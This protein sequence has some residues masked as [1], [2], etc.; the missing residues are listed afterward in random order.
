[1]AK[2]SLILQ[3]D[4]SAEGFMGRPEVLLHTARVA[5][6]DIETFV[7]AASSSKELLAEKNYV[8]A[9]GSG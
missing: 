6:G 9:L 5:H 2:P 8:L 4:T 7:K 3:F 1:M